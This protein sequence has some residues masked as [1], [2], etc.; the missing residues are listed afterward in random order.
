MVLSDRWP[1]LTVSGDLTTTTTAEGM[2]EA[3]R[4]ESSSSLK[5]EQIFTGGPC[6][7]VPRRSR[8]S[9]AAGCAKC[10]FAFG[11]SG[12]AGVA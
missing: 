10:R 3:A 1:G 11:L 9:S 5:D 2:Q 7:T 8:R 4:H 12:L 6:S